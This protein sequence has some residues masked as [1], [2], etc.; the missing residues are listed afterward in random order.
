MPRGFTDTIMMIRPAAFGYNAQTAVSNVFQSKPESTSEEVAIKAIDEFDRFVDLLRANKLNVEVIE[1]TA[2]PVKPDAVFPN[3]WI[4]FHEDGS[5]VTYPMRTRNRRVE[6]RPD[7]VEQMMK[8]YGF[9]SEVQLGHYTAAQ[10][11]LEGTGSMVLD[12][13]NAICY[14]CLS[15]RTDERLLLEFCKLKGYELIVF[16]A[17]DQTGKDIYHTN[18][19][20]AIGDGYVVICL[21]AVEDEDER[22]VLI[23]S[24]NKTGKEVVDISFDQMNAYAGNMLHVIN[25]DGEG[26]LVCSQTALES[27]SDDQIAQI[28]KYARLVSSDITTIQTIGG[29]SVRCM[30]AE[31]FVP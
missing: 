15:P 19:M 25:S 7:L 6:Y 24:F 4:S 12:R 8:Q 1:D 18:V 14:A 5:I 20:M 22:E 29:G 30:M 21:E 10:I 2:D 9:N 11:Y 31:V 23:E 28:K 13:V 3:N 27:L 17:L 26:L 16:D